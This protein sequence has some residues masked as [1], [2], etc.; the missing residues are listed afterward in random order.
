MRSPRGARVVTRRRLARGW[1]V[2][3]RH[4]RT[5]VVGL[6]TPPCPTPPGTALLADRVTVRWRRR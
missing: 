4:D 3:L 2:R 5:D 6:S 1:L